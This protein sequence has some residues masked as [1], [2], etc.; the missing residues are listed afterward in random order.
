MDKNY[1]VYAHVFPN[2]KKYIGITCKPY[3]ERWGKNGTGYKKQK[4]FD[5]ICYYG[6]KNIKHYILYKNLTWEEAL[7]KEEE[8]INKY[9]TTDKQYGYNTSEGKDSR[10][11]ICINTGIVYDNAKL[12]AKDYIGITTDKDIRRCC[13]G[14][15]SYAGI[16]P[17]SNDRLIWM[18]YIDYRKDIV[19]KLRERS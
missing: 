12:A 11:V 1:I 10:E 14:T 2:G 18:K 5:A 3:L 13:R 17:I 19:N 16:D 8:L 6:W 9:N 4:V 15:I 7:L